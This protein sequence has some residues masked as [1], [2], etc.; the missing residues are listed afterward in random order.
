[1]NKF[2]KLVVGT[3][4]AMFASFSF[5]FTVDTSKQVGPLE[6]HWWNSPAGSQVGWGLSVHQQYETVMLLLYTYKVDRTPVWYIA[7]C[8]I[9]NGNTC[10]TD[11][12]VTDKGYPLPTWGKNA[13]VT[14]T[15]AGYITLF[16][17][18]NDSAQMSYY[19]AIPAGGTGTG[20][21]QYIERFI[22]DN[23]APK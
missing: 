11:L 3:L 19:I 4:L 7:T 8:K 18:S 5:A 13:D 21:G 9:E 20:W 17:D 23:S 1:M 12:Y 16:F 6:G 15:K 2:T 14:A 10:N 22:F